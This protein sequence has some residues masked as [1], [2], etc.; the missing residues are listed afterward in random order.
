MDKAGTLVYVAARQW[1][2][3]DPDEG[4][5]DRRLFGFGRRA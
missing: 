3:G 5:Q 4:S 2:R 1:P